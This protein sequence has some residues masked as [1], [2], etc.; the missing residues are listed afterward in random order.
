MATATMKTRKVE[1]NFTEAL[2]QSAHHCHQ[3]DDGND[4]MGSWNVK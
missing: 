4:A 3:H 2:K 1:E